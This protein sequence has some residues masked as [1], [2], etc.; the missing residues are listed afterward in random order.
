[1][2]KANILICDDEEGVRET[3]KHML[4]G[5]Y[6]LSFAANGEEAVE[7]VR[8]NDPAIAIMDI[9]M[10]KM[11]GLEALRRI[12]ELKPGVRVVIITG[13]E[14]TDVATEAINLGADDYITKP[15]RQQ[16]ILTQVRALLDS[17]KA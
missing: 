5:E 1:M 8:A 10:P 3:L 13:Y 15:F 2:K 12:K 16:K 6:E 4:G 7:H 17:G 11:N 9:K 14:A